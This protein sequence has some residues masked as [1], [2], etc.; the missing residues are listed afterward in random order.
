MIS[1]EKAFG[2]RTNLTQA[3]HERAGFFVQEEL[4][5]RSVSIWIIMLIAI[6]LPVA[7]GR[8]PNEAV[9]PERS[10]LQ[11]VDVAHYQGHIDWAELAGD[12]TAFAYIKAT[13]GVSLIDPRFEDN[14]AGARRV[15]L[16]RGAYH[17]F[18]SCQTGRD[19][20]QHFLAVVPD[21][22]GVLPPV[23]DVEQNKP[24]TD[25]ADTDLPMTDAV[26]E[27]LDA[28]E[29][30]RGVRPVIYTNKRFYNEHFS[31]SLAH[32]AYWL[33]SLNGEPDY[34][35][36][37]WLFWQ[38]TDKGRR[39]GISGSV[40]LNVFAGNAEKLRALAGDK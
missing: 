6:I 17:F 39:R 11:G 34:G 25:Y 36:G 9:A 7:C 20:A 29:A 38:Y 33:R 2:T 37:S 4:V 24:C 14:W 30:E 40:D 22:D 13:E 21:S 35:P 10:Y 3:G 31:G 28:V 26:T 18:T 32:E 23:L 8:S 19:Q 27:F 5:Y 15:G 16:L 1:F 12:D